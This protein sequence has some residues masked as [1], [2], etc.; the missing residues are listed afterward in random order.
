[1]ISQ[2]IFLYV[3]YRLQITGANHEYFELI[4]FVIST[5]SVRVTIINRDRMR[6]D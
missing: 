3:L 1:M 5:E 4:Y 2:N 6:G